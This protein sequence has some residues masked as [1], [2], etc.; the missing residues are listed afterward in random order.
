MGF[1]RL[2]A[3]PVTPI[4]G[5]VQ[6]QADFMFANRVFYAPYANQ[7]RQTFTQAVV[8]TG[9]NIQGNIDIGVYD[10]NFALLWKLGTTALP[11]PGTKT[12]TITPSLTLGVGLYYL[13]SVF[14]TGG[15]NTNMSNGQPGG[16]GLAGAY[17]ENTFPLPTVPTPVAVETGHGSTE[18]MAA[19]RLTLQ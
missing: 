17:Y 19:L 9:T 14:D 6:S 11:S 15:A 12:Y 18:G 1:P 10:R 5:F 7:S 13:A 4:K 16:T 8:Q 3:F 2:I